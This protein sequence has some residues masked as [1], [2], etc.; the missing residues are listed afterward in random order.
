MMSLIR[1][2]SYYS[3][4]LRQVFQAASVPGLQGTA[5]RK[6][7]SIVF[8]RVTRLNYYKRNIL[9]KDHRRH[10]TMHTNKN[11][12]KFTKCKISR[13]YKTNTVRYEIEQYQKTF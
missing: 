4:L 7:R 5:P 6:I 11:T 3:W 12:N 9:E 2:V 13:F 1:L 8:T 10:Q